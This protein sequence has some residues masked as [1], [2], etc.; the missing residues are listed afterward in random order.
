VK[1]SGI[2]AEVLPGLFPGSFRVKHR[3]AGSPRVTLCILTNDRSRK[4]PGRGHINLVSHFVRSIAEKTDYPKY[5]ILIVDDD[6]LSTATRKTLEGIDY[7]LVSFTESVR[8]FNFSKK[9]NFTVSRVN[10]EHFI[11]L[12][13]DLEVITPEWVS[14]LV[15]FTQQKEIG[16]AGARLIFP[17]DTVQHAGMI[18]G[19][20]GHTAH[21]FRLCAR[22]LIGYNGYTHVIR[23]YAAVTGACLATR[24]SVFHQ[25]GGFDEQLAIDFNDVDFCLSALSRG[26]RI[27]YTPYSE[28]YHFENSSIERESQHPK[29]AARFRQRWAK[30]I[31]R[32]PYYNPN[33]TRYGWDFTECA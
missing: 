23:N 3:I 27:V 8:P 17:D 15:E 25:A 12:N 31:D 9:V 22:N 19:V 10:T 20:D 28:L 16:C 13:D 11:L 1:A 18:L 32:D 5:E 7:R 24:K 30:W 33:L 6:N 26:Y 29:E 2:D 14:A 21:A 4:V